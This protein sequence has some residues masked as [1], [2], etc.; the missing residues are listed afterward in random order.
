MGDAGSLFL[1]FM[2]AVL[3]LKLRAN[4]PTRVEVA[5]ILA[6]PGVALFDTTLVMVSRVLHRRNPFS[7]G[8]D[9]TSHRLVYLGLSVRKAV[10]ADLLAWGRP[11]G[12][13]AIAMTQVP[14]ARFVGV[15]AL[16]GVAAC[17]QRFPCTACLSTRCRGRRRRVASSLR[18][19][20]RRRGLARQTAVAQAPRLSN[21]QSQRPGRQPRLDV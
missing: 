9:H 16:L 10:A 7:G 18:C 17:S 19:P 20:T 13:V 4:A 1:G 12:G 2:I 11:S 6:V 3:L 15:A 8:Q 5:V 21:F 14:S